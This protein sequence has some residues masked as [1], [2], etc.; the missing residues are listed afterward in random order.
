[1][2]YVEFARALAN[3]ALPNLPYMEVVQLP[4]PTERL[5]WNAM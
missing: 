4:S 2:H 1:M 5:R 3:R